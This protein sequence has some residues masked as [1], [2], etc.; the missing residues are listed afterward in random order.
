M[1]VTITGTLIDGSA[2]TNIGLPGMYTI[3]GLTATT[4]TLANVALD[5]D[6]TRHCNGVLGPAA[7]LP[8]TVTGYDPLLH[9][10]VPT[11]ST[12]PGGI[13]IGGDT[14][15]RRLR[16]TVVV[17][18]GGR[19]ADEPR[20][21]PTGRTTG[22]PSARPSRSAGSAPASSRTSPTRCSAPA[23]VIIFDDRR[24]DP[25]RRRQPHRRHAGRAVLAGPNSPLVVYGDT[26]QDGVWYSGHPD[27][28]A[29]L[30]V[31]RRSRSTR[32]RTSRT[33]RTRTTSGCFPLANPYDYAGNDVIDA[34]RAVRRR[35]LHAALRPA[36]A[37]ASPPTA[38]PATT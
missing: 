5:A 6:A 28:V 23:R 24:P 20:P 12:G 29:R 30:R 27:D 9:E 31:R 1:Q 8:L 13:R 3:S 18:V 2:I 22:S 7:P 35:H 25:G 32:S 15:T 37:S 4:M 26:S 10:T 38:A 21:V 34:Q 19:P 11:V 14:I 36:D 33:P 16:K 17:N